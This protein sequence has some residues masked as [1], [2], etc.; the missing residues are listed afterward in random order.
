MNIPPD[1]GVALV[2]VY[3]AVGLQMRLYHRLVGQATTTLD[4][5]TAVT[6]AATAY[7]NGLVFG[8]GKSLN[9]GLFTG[10]VGPGIYVPKALTKQQ[11]DS[12]TAFV[13]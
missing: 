10:I 8:S 6:S 12:L 2:A 5:T 13:L 9:P 3:D 11:I 1:R 7:S 4:A